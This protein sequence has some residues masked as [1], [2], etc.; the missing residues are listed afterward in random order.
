[1]VVDGH[2]RPPFL[3]SLLLRSTKGTGTKGPE[4]LHELYQ[5]VRTGVTVCT[6]Y[7]LSYKVM[8][9]LAMRLRPVDGYKAR[10]LG[11]LHSGESARKPVKRYL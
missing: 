4:G 2:E 1:M 7:W 6:A 8:P 5:K 9:T 3:G 10:S 11:T